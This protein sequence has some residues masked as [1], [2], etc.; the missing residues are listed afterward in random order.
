ML[1]LGLILTLVSSDRVLPWVLVALVILVLKAGD[2]VPG[3]RNQA[4]LASYGRICDNPPRSW[5]IGLM[6]SVAIGARDPSVFAFAFCL[7]S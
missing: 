5:Q 1:Q 6:F 2:A 3:N 7:S 4:Q